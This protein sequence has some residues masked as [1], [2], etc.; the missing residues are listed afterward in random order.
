VAAPVTALFA[1]NYASATPYLT[2][3]EYLAEPTGVD[4]SQLLPQVT[5]LAA[6]TAAL[7]RQ[8]QRASSWA[9]QY[10]RKILAATSDVQAGEYRIFRDGTIRVPVDNTPLIQVTDVALGQV[11]GQLTSLSDL[12]GCWVGRKV[13]RIPAA[14]AAMPYR[15]PDFMS[16]AR[17]GWMFA[18][19]TYVNGWAH[20]Q[21]AAGSAAGARVQQV[22]GT[23]LGIVPGL[24]LTVYD[25][26]ANGANTEQVAVASTYQFGSPFVPLTAP[27]VNGH[28]AGCSVSALP[29]FVRQ[30][31]ISMTSFL[32]KTRGSDSFVIPEGPGPVEHEVPM[33]AGASEDVDLAME[34]LEPLRRVW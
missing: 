11:A 12:S 13:V 14:A 30:A 34:L 32:I 20:A 21:T 15:P 27:M 24:V 10:V 18:K 9:D 8:I 29:P 28:A 23:G 7:V 1:P 3:A 19:V 2:P 31:V 4:V 6:Q 22:T 5:S 17:A 33:M 25:G 26:T 16:T